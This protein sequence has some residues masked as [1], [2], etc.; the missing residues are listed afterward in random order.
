D[1]GR[2]NIMLGVEWYN[3]E[4]VGQRDR[5][6][7][8]EGWFDPDANAGGLLV[9][10]GFAF[11]SGAPRPTQAAVDQVFFDAHGI[12]PG[13]IDVDTINEIYFNPDSTPFTLQGARGYTGPFG[14]TELGEGSAGVR[15]NANGNL[16]QQCMH[17]MASTPQERRSVFGRATYD[18]SDNLS[19]FAQ[20]TYTNNLVTT[21]GGIPPAITVWQAYAPN[22]GRDIPDALQTLLDQRE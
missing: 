6:F 19:A 11:A 14:A 8:R 20:V 12:A 2:G 13:T 22:D 16:G 15:V 1:K 7:Y 9:A 3:R 4:V 5:D 21:T 17:G 18:L 10:P